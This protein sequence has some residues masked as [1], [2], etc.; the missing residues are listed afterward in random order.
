LQDNHREQILSV[1]PDLVLVEVPAHQVGHVEG[2]EV[3]LAE[4]GNRAHY[5]GELDWEDYVKFFTHSLKWV[6]LCSTGF[7]DNITPQVLDGSVTLTNAPGLHTNPIAESVLAAMLDHAKNLRQRRVDQKNHEWN[8]LQNEELHGRTVCIIGLGKIGRKVADICAAFG[9]RVCGAR[10]C[11]EPVENVE[12]V[13]PMDRLDAHLHEADYVVLALP[14]TTDTEELLGQHQFYAMKQSAYLINVGRGK[15]IAESAMISALRERR[16][17]GAY[18]DA[19]VE[20]PLRSDHPLW[21]MDNVLLVPHDS[22]SSPHI[23]DRMVDIFCENLE[24][25]VS[26]KSLANVCDPSKGY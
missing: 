9:M 12:L 5:A 4:G 6:Q 13:F 10:R 19:F 21:E 3:L 25:Y 20:E 23:G 11:L 17:A 14:L 7:S 26:G 22:H 24:R 1:S 15:C 8:R 18:L 16:I 2:I